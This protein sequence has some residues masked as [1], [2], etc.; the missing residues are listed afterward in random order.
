MYTPAAFRNNDPL[1]AVDSVSRFG[2]ATLVTVQNDG[3][4]VSHLPMIADPVNRCIRGHLARANPHALAIDGRRCLVA[5]TGANAYVSPDWYGDAEQ[6]PTWNY[7]AV[8]IEGVAHVIEEPERVDALL[9]ELSEFH[10]RRRHNLDVGKIWT[11][12]KLPVQK[13][14][15]LRA[16]IVAFEIPIEKIELKAKLN[17]N[18]G[19]GDFRSVVE[20][21]A[22]GDENQRAVANA[23]LA[24][25]P[26]LR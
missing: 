8:H 3:P 20:K 18:K 7:S 23:M 25:A 5:M 1:A 16:A 4:A 15:K 11:L 13:L 9:D 21:L 19:A 12:A 6:V 26:K 2:F 10:E 17:Q 14:R 24:A 22:A